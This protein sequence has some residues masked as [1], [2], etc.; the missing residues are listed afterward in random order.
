M[1]IKTQSTSVCQGLK[2]YTNPANT[3]HLYNICTTSSQRLRRWP[4]IVQMLYKCFV[5]A[6]NAVQHYNIHVNVMPAT[7]LVSRSSNLIFPTDQPA[8][9]PYTTYPIINSRAVIQNSA[10]S[11]IFTNS[12]VGL[13]IWHLCKYTPKWV[14]QAIW[15]SPIKAIADFLFVCFAVSHYFFV[16]VCCFAVSLFLLQC[17]GV[18]S[19]FS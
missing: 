13:Y 12:S 6:G 2:H 1:L 5:F 14:S 9:S 15:S 7:M 8:F 3:K 18:V 17:H 11:C 19:L 4:N 10:S 16:F